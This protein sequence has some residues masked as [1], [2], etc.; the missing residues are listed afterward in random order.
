L[1]SFQKLFL[2]FIQHN[3]LFMSISYLFNFAVTLTVVVQ[4]QQSVHSERVS[5]INT[6]IRGSVCLLLKHICAYVYFLTFQ[7]DPPCIALIL[8]KFF[9][10]CM[11]YYVIKINN[12]KTKLSSAVYFQIIL[13][14]GSQKVMFCFFI[15]N[16]NKLY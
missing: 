14:E 2:S 16:I 7:V 8:I 12:I 4:Y 3:I 6:T 5:V 10:I 1:Y 9:S 11:R 13:Y 15:S